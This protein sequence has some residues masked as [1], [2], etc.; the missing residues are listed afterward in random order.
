MPVRVEN[1]PAARETD[2]TEHG[3]LL[4]QGLSSVLIGLAGASGNILEGQRACVDARAGRNPPPGTLDP[5][6]NVIQPN[7]PGQ[8]YNN[9]GVEASRQVINR[10][11][12]GGLTQEGL[13]DQAMNDGLANK[14]PQGLWWSGGTGQSG[15]Q[16]LWK[17][18]NVDSSLESSSLANL[19]TSVAQGK[20]VAVEL[21][22]NTLWSNGTTPPKMHNHVVLATGVRYDKDGNVTHV[23]INDTGTGKCSQEVPIN[24]WN[25]STNPGWN[26]VVTDKPIW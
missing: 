14:D 8:S 17:K 20:G 6:G 16:E 2:T 10:A 3:G 19:E 11:T 13:L 22:A 15:L 1:L 9:C 21:D 18:N 25:L 4:T 5:N 12:G 26:N 24:V 23:I 7:T